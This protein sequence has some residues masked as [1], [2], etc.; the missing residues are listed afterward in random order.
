MKLSPLSNHKAVLKKTNFLSKLVTRGDC[1]QEKLT[2]SGLG[3]TLSKLGIGR[4]ANWF[5]EHLDKGMEA[6]NNAS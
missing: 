5:G 2:G 6:S 4:L 1:W 3:S